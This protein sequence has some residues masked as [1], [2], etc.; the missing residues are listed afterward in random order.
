MG[1][2]DMSEGSEC[3]VIPL[4]L[5]LSFDG[6]PDQEDTFDLENS[7]F[8][9]YMSYPLELLDVSRNRPFPSKKVSEDFD[10]SPQ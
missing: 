6:S 1:R 4:K 5:L 8:S 10:E 2:D 9:E 7:F 3:L